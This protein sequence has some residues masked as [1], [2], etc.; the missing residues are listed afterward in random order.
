M[1]NF[2]NIGSIW[3]RDCRSHIR[4]NFLYLFNSKKDNGFV[5]KMRINKLQQLPNS[6]WVLTL[7]SSSLFVT[8]S[9]QYLGLNY[10]SP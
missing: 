1:N 4:P 3:A 10:F 8:I 6:E 7:S 2:K 9:I 5:K